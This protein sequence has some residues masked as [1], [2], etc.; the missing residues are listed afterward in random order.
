MENLPI[1]ANRHLRFQKCLPT[2]ISQSAVK[3]ANGAGSVN[4]RLPF[5]LW[6]MTANGFSAPK[7]ET[8]D[9]RS[10][11]LVRLPVHSAGMAEAKE[12]SAAPSFIGQDTPA[13][14]R[15]ALSGHQVDIL[16]NCLIDRAISE[17]MEV[18]GRTDRT[19]FRNQ[20]LNPLLDDGLIEMTIPGKRTS[21]KQKYRLT[22]KGRDVIGG[23][24]K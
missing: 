4:Y 23:F 3:V 12:E 7:F 6:A 17:L 18:S 24:D 21:S 22:R 2:E 11:Y 9:E 10:S 1:N 13:G 8:D 14:T 5:I 16:R 15:L 20:V 19:K